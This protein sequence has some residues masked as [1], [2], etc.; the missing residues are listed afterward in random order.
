MDEELIK[1]YE[2]LSKQVAGAKA[3]A[4]PKAP[5]AKKVVAADL[6]EMS[7]PEIHTPSEVAV[8][9]VK[10]PRV[11]KAVAPPLAERAGVSEP[12]NARLAPMAPEA[13]A[14]VAPVAPKKPR[15]APKPKAPKETTVAAPLSNTLVLN[16]PVR[17]G[18]HKCVCETCGKS[19]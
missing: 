17:V 11:P 9:K 4:P 2:M 13:V 3:A 15:A 7:V 6:M 5:R 8:P 12:R 10:K 1:L 14:P 18:K 19:I 16:A